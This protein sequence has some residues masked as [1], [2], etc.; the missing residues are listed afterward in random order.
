[1]RLAIISD[2]HS[3]IEALNAVLKDINDKNIDSTICLGDLVGYCPYPNE[4]IN[5]I[6]EKNV[7]TIMGNYDDAVGNELLICGCDYPD[8]K[9]MDN[10][11]ISLNWTI[12]AVNGEN[13]KYLRELPRE[14]ILKFEGK[15]IYFVHGSPRQMTEY[16]KENSKEADEVMAA[17]NEDILVSGHTHLPYKKMYGNKILINS[18]SVGKPKTGHPDANYIIIDITNEKVDVEIIDVPYD[19]EKIAKSIEE[20]GLPEKFA[21]IIRTGRG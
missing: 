4:V 20:N 3:N 18:G 2:I 9:D 7:L 6:R 10:A 8:P 17:L 19:Y 11:S 15:T 1:M 5:R 13:K 12:D 21:Q 16:L 14:M